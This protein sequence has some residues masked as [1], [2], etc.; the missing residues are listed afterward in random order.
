MLELAASQHSLPGSPLAIGV[1]HEAQI[2][3]LFS[4]SVLAAKSLLDILITMAPGH[5]KALTNLEWISLS[6]AVS[7]S[8]RLDVLMADP[9]IA[10]LTSQAR[11]RLGFQ[12]TIRQAILRLR[13]IITPG[14]DRSGDCDTFSHFLRRAETVEVRSSRQVRSPTAPSDVVATPS[15][16]EPTVAEREAVP[17]G[18]GTGESTNLF[19]VDF[20]T[21]MQGTGPWTPH[22]SDD[23]D[24]T[25]GD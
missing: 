22:F 9:R 21:E 23:F 25:W 15:S 18:D 13:S 3:G 1:E 10:H 24:M 12:Y 5:E 6:Y 20:F 7:F 16:R 11:R 4:D 14:T 19:A 2:T 8:A 17:L